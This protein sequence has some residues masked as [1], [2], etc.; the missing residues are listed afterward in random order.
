MKISLLEIFGLTTLCLLMAGCSSK[1]SESDLRDGLKSWLGANHA[2]SSN[3]GDSTKMD[4][5]DCKKVDDDAFKNLNQYLNFS[6][7][8]QANMKNLGYACDVSFAG[9]QSLPIFAVQVKKDGAWVAQPVFL[10]DPRER[11][12]IQQIFNVTH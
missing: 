6:E 11:G 9:T 1:P 7:P 8:D 2:F 10:P 12:L 3:F 5:K 4:V